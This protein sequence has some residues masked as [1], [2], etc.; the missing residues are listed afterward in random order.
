MISGFS[1]DFTGTILYDDSI[2]WINPCTDF[3]FQGKPIVA[4]GLSEAIEEFIG[5]KTKSNGLW[6][7]RYRMLSFMV[8]PSF[9]FVSLVKF[10]FE[11]I[12]RTTS[13]WDR[14]C[15]LRSG[16]SKMRTGNG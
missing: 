7:G 15:L 12:Q 2:Q 16:L 8:P 6:I 13:E 14:N 1:S 11:F 9:F 3:Q 4:K 5:G 10:F